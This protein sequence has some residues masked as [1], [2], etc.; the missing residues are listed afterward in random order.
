M[1]APEYS[2]SPYVFWSC[3]HKNAA[4]IIGLPQEISFAFSGSSR[5]SDV[6]IYIPL[7]PYGVCTLN[8]CLYPIICNHYV[9]FN[10][11]VMYNANICVEK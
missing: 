7:F 10:V 9:E 1:Q 6:Y 4:Y 3:H 5:A 11:E 8:I 2:V